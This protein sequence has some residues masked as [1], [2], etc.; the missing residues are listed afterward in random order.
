VFPGTFTKATILPPEKPVMASEPAKHG[1]VNGR[2]T[3]S[4]SFFVMMNWPARAPF[5]IV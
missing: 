2:S 1:I 5:G 3:A 4:V